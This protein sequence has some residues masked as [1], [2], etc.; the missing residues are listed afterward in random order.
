MA[1]IVNSRKST[2]TNVPKFDH[3]S[4]PQK[5]NVRCC[6][7]SIVPRKTSN[8]E[9]L[10]KT[11]IQQAPFNWNT[12]LPTTSFQQTLQLLLLLFFFFFFVFSY[13]SQFPKATNA[14]RFFT[15]SKLVFIFDNLIVTTKGRRIWTL[16]LLVIVKE[17]RQCDWSTSSY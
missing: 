2:N 16:I 4:K 11:K 6:P 7:S 17:S 8:N 13:H 10:Y 1:W 12:I 15:S 9:S 14:S 5:V 3:P